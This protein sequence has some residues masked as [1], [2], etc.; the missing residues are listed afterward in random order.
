MAARDLGGDDVFQ[1][2]G[3]DV[4]DGLDVGDELRRAAGRFAD[5]VRRGILVR[6]SGRAGFPSFNFPALL[7][8][9]RHQ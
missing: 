5:V 6:G 2:D 3:L 9:H 7:G 8:V 4:D 1:L